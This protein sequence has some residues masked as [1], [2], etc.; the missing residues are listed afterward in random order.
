MPLEE[1]E[2]A[3]DVVDQAGPARQQEHGTDATRSEALDAIGNLVL[4]VAGGHHGSIA[5]GFVPILD[6]IED[7]PLA[8]VESSLVAFSSLVTV[9]FP[10]LFGDSST[11]S[12]A[13]LE[14]NSEDV[15]LPPLFQ[16]PREFSSFF[17]ENLARR[18]KF[19]LG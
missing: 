4:D 8:I 12:K 1:V 5:L 19:T 9:A 14:W 18:E 16:K 3:V 7:S 6:A 11:H 15:L 17:F 13:P 10:G 2:I